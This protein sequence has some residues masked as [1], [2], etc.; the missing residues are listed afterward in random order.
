MLVRAA[1]N[2]DLSRTDEERR[3]QLLWRAGKLLLEEIDGVSRRNSGGILAKLHGQYE[4]VFL[5]AVEATAGAG[6]PGGSYV[7]YLTATCQHL[8]GERER[9]GNKNALLEAGADATA[10]AWVAKKKGEVTS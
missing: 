9:V 6:K 7:E 1:E 2:L 5:D 4:A 3:K 10:A 8:A